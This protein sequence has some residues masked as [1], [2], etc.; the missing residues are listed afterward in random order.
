M[1]LGNTAGKTICDQLVPMTPLSSS[2]VRDSGLRERD[3]WFTRGLTLLQHNAR[4]YCVAYIGA[5]F[6]KRIEE[7][8][9]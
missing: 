8:T 3:R 1:E 4:L 6:P 9:T 5:A 7:H 2:S